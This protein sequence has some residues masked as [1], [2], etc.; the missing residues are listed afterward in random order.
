MLGSTRHM[1]KE[2]VAPEVTADMPPT[3]ASERATLSMDQLFQRVLLRYI[4]GKILIVIMERQRFTR[5]LTVL[6]EIQWWLRSLV[7]SMW[8]PK[9]MGWRQLPC[10]HPT[11]QF[12]RARALLEAP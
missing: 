3:Q 9:P 2:L 1:E 12:S 11:L 10:R 4:M 5:M 8:R 7:P 6:Q